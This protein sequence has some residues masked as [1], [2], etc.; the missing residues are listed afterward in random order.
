MS[1]KV[2]SAIAD[3]ASR[4]IGQPAEANGKP[5]QMP[6]STPAARQHWWKA[7]L[8]ALLVVAAVYAVYRFGS[9]RAVLPEGLIQANGR[10]E[11]DTISIASKFPGRIDKIFVREGDQVTEGQ[12]VA[13]LEDDQVRAKVA[14]ARQALIAAESQLA[15]AQSALETDR[16]EVP[17]SVQAATSAVARAEADQTK[18]GAAEQQA[19]RDA[20]RFDRL[21][22]K[23]SIG[24]Q[25]AEQA[26]L[27]F[28]TAHSDLESAGTALNEAQQ[29]LS[30]AQLGWDRIRSKEGEVQ[31]LQAQAGEARAAL[32][33]AESTLKDLTIR[34]PISGIVTNKIRD[35][36]EVV[37]A[38]APLYEIVDLDKL[39]LKVYVPENQVGKVRLHAPAQVFTDAYPDQPF[40]ATT[41]YI[42]SRAE[43]TPKEVQTADERVKLV[44]AL[45]LYLDANPDHRLTPG[46]SAD[47]VI[48]WKEGVPWAKPRT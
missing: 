10:I 25:R 21:A 22:A 18:A 36:G 27:A 32:E 24:K 13:R 43:F 2:P 44:F 47:A 45:K 40:A 8:A 31:A 35:I 46:M 14:Q 1:S 41:R 28:T 12:V 3:D 9:N 7:I 30:L 17:L 15:A 6:P 37:S 34:S 23:G 29:Q 33:D 4:A 16:K 42:S 48:R 38:G 19:S 20:E 26:E 5:T 11:G 39:Y